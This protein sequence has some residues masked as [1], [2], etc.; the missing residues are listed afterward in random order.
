MM[1]LSR[2]RI[3]RW[4]HDHVQA[5][6][7]WF[8]RIVIGEKLCPFAPPFLNS[9][10]LRVAVS[11][12]QDVGQA[13][14][15]IKLELNLLFPPSSDEKVDRSKINATE[16]QKV[17]LP[18]HET[19]LVVFDS[20]FVKDFREFVRLSWALQSESVLSFGYHK[21]VQLVLFHPNATHQTYAGNGESNAADYTIRSPYPTI[22]LLRELDVLRV[23]SGRYPNVEEIPSRNKKRF[24]DQ[25]V[26]VCQDRL[27]QCY[28]YGGSAKTPVH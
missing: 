3:F 15:D 16:K 7:L 28:E 27:N 8:E 26:A 4:N 24:L 14:A 13:V 1:D 21:V 23:V 11:R 12:A 6:K 10:A 2:R 25:G 18:N 22:H 17:S 5:T 9:S 19:T 20:P